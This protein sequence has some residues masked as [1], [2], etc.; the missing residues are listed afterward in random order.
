MENQEFFWTW[1]NKR[2]QKYPRRTYKSHIGYPAS[3]AASCHKYS[4]KDIVRKVDFI[5]ADSK[6]HNLNKVIDKV[7]KISMKIA[8]LSDEFISKPY[9]LLIQCF[10]DT[11]LQ[12]F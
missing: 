11:L 10:L 7:K 4:S 2:I 9:I 12:C 5:V 3:S 1:C 8:F 6:A